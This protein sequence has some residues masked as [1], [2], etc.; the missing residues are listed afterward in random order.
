MRKNQEFINRLKP[1][2]DR[3]LRELRA[4]ARVDA[5]LE[6]ATDKLHQI[7]SSISANEVPEELKRKADGI[8]SLIEEAEEPLERAISHHEIVEEGEKAHAESST[9]VKTLQNWASFK[10]I[11][12]ATQ[13]K[14]EEIQLKKEDID[15][16][17]EKAHRILA[18]VDE[19]KTAQEREKTSQFQQHSE[20]KS[21][22]R[23]LSE[24]LEN[25]RTLIGGAERDERI[26]KLIAELKAQ[27]R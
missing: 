23:M 7:T 9:P 1:E 21:T 22:A 8:K 17:E 18:L 2:L 11:N 12:A 26:S 3:E 6:T 13:E 27:A 19:L 20:F 10:N 24:Y 4:T 16:A 5:A 14:V 15:L 25:L